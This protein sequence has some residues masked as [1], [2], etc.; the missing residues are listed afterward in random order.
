MHLHPTD[1]VVEE[2][3]QRMSDRVAANIVEIVADDITEVTQ[4]QNLLRHYVVHDLSKDTPPDP[5][6]GAYFSMNVDIKNHIYMAKLAL[7]TTILL[8]SRECMLEITRVAENRK[9]KHSS[10]CPYV[11][12]DAPDVI[13]QPTRQL[14]SAE[15]ENKNDTLVMME[16]VTLLLL[17]MM[18]HMINH[19][20]ECIKQTGRK[21]CLQLH[22][23]NR[24]N[25]KTT[26]C[27]L[28]LFFIC[29]RTNVEYS[30]V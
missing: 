14:Q 26:H 9:G 17:L 25:L 30:V 20:F 24:H 22:Y 4:V 7:L 3:S 12:K 1:K 29:V 10:F 8:G 16:L 2:F 28:A 6:D 21:S 13:A 19:S 15:G 23:S 5:D 18:V 11:R 27:E